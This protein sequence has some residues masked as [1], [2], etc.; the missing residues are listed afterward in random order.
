M[1]RAPLPSLTSFV[2]AVAALAVA[3]LGPAGCATQRPVTS[4]SAPSPATIFRSLLGSNPGLTA[5]RAVA[6]AR[7]FLAGTEVSLPGVLQLDSFGGFRLDL[8][9]PLDRPLAMLFAEE[10]RIVSYRPGVALASS[11]A[12]FPAECS[13]IDPSAWVQAVLSSSL[14]PVA[15]ERIADRRV[16]GGGRV[17]ERHRGDLLYQSIGYET[18]G[19]LMVPNLVSWYCG[20]DPVMQ[21]RLR[22]WAPGA[23][24][25]LPSRFE[26]LFPRAGLEIK[27]ELSEIEGNPPPSN[28]PFHPRLGPEVRW[29]AWNIPQ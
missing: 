21:V 20:E 18:K 7:I 3:S 14:S 25:R 4:G 9:D 23:S 13:G 22:A 28:Q 6:E 24:W 5:V 12:V 1:R 27:V 26:V 29:T 10:G 2:L 19:D 16:W 15:G 11:L 8:L 17:L